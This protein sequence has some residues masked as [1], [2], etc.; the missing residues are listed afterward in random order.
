MTGNY[1]PPPEPGQS[2]QVRTEQAIQYT[3]PYPLAASEP[4]EEGVNWGR[5][6]AALVRY[7]WLMMLIVLVGTGIGVGITQF[8]TPEYRSRST[9][10]IDSQGGKNGPIQAG[11]LV[12][13]TDWIQLLRSYQVMDSVVLRLGLFVQPKDAA[14]S[15]TFHGF[16]LSR[17]FYPGKYQLRIDPTG[18]HFTLVNQDGIEVQQGA[19]GDSVGQRI[20][21]LWQPSPAELKRDRT[22]KFKILTPRDASNDL[23]GRLGSS[24]AGQDMQRGRGGGPT[25]LNLTLTDT[26]P[27]R[28]AAALNMIDSQ[29]VSM[30]GDLKS[31]QLRELS[32]IL[33]SQLDTVGQQ[34]HDAEERLKSYEIKV[35][36]EP[37]QDV[38]V[39][40]GVAATQAPVLGNYFQQ[41][42]Q[43]E[44]L[45]TDRQALE[46]VLGR[47]KN[48]AQTVDAFQTIPV[49]RTA[50][51]LSA[52][53]QELQQS[54]AELR[55]LRYRYTDQ[56]KPV[57]DVLARIQE[58]RTQ[59]IPSLAAA[60]VAQLKIQENEMENQ[61]AGA[62]QELRAIP[63]RSIEEARLSREVAAKQSLFQEIQ[64]RYETNKLAVA[65]SG[66]DITILDEA[67]PPLK[68]TSNTAPKII[69]MAL[70][71]SMGLA[72]ALALLLDQLDKRFR[73]PE[74][75]SHELGLPIL[76][77]VPAIRRTGGRQLSTEEASQVVE[78]FRTIRLNLVHSY[79]AGPVL[80]TVS[81]P[82]PGDGKSL[83]S[84]N[85]AL[86]F[87]E[88]GYRTLL[89]DGDIR[90]GELHRMFSIERRPGLLDY[91]MGDAELQALLRTSE[92]EG[93]SIIPCGTR[94]QQG[95]ELLG[96]AAMGQLM[97][98]MKSRFNVIIVDS[99][100]LSAGIDPFVLGTMTGNLLMV[101]RSGETDK[102]MAQ[103]KLRLLERLPV[104]VLGAVL[105]EIRAEG[106]Y[107][108]YS[109]L[110]GYT[111][112]EETPQIAAG[113]RVS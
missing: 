92:H 96:S 75:V 46:G 7:K 88:A 56:H 76:G 113:E 94:R 22:I 103:Q 70:A 24:V 44:Q 30:A 58:L 36:T 23:M 97:G 112:D 77:A 53:L 41:K 38:A 63:T 14:D 52:A 83:V 33:K 105:N 59:T 29:F 43:L 47:L 106:V 111:S 87:A 102:N 72:V 9:L 6:I 64:S 19:V 42:A 35:I 80:L 48:G 15:L 5:Y 3:E 31:R 55:A 34:L 57:Q 107:R 93:L 79:G 37:T 50:P 60:L 98:E 71:A 54:E 21:F 40:P 104:R 110:Y 32:V 84:S 49:V 39:A 51:N 28:A 8:I 95:P 2:V 26:D 1:L 66:N 61:I 17:R 100:P 108:Y 74:Q 89:V 109:Y 16:R 78:A 90:R 81:S 86:S 69:L 45:R 25:F 11:N 91:L 20:G 62:S 68:P 12:Q 73:Y 4:P 13:G 65:S 18:Q 67:R 82:G 85:L 27:Y 99:P 101:F 10:W